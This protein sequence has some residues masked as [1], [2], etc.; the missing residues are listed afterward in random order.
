MPVNRANEV[1]KYFLGKK[2]QL[3]PDYQ[4]NIF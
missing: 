2:T 1:F 4:L 3:N